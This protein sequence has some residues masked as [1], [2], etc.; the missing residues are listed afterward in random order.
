M[1]N[2]PEPELL[3]VLADGGGGTAGG[4]GCGCA[5]ENRREQIVRRETA[6]AAGTRPRPT[7]DPDKPLLPA[8]R[9]DEQAPKADSI[10]AQSLTLPSFP[11]FAYAD[12]SPCERDPRTCSGPS[13]PPPHGLLV[14]T[15]RLL[16]SPVET[17]PL[18]PPF[19]PFRNRHSFRSGV[20]QSRAPR[21]APLFRAFINPAPHISADPLIC[22]ATGA[23]EL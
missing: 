5:Q 16:G 23:A 12:T 9:S 6:G 18:F 21:P 7:R 10:T 14:L 2:S 17:A 4:G 8:G 11:S 3:V 22:L 13:A 15:H 20:A 1:R 19:G